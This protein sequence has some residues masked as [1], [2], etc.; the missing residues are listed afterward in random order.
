MVDLC[1]H[2]Y[3]DVISTK[4]THAHILMRTIYAYMYNRKMFHDMSY[5]L[6]CHKYSLTMNITDSVTSLPS[7]T[8]YTSLSQTIKV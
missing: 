7:F 5:T 1:Q 2:A 3:A 6:A 4:E 8:L